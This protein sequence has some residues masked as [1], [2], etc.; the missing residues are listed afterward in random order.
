MSRRDNAAYRC[1]ACLMHQTLCIC[2]ELP[3]LTLRHRICLVMHREEVRKT[4]NTGR[5]AKLCMPDTQML[6]HG[7]QKH[8]AVL[9]G[10][11]ERHRLLLFPHADAQVLTKGH[12]KD[13]RLTLVVPDGTWRQASKM[14]RRLPWMENLPRVT[15]PPGPKTHYD[16]RSALKPGGLATFEAIARALGILEGA[17]VQQSLERVFRLMVERTLFSRGLLSRSAVFE[18]IEEHI[19][20]HNPRA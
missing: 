4:T 10:A 5:L 1:P 3:K 6:I 8:P 11:P 15:L 14:C 2:P 18:G 17:A 9:T 19:K 7:D 20:Q 12:A 13:R 16:L